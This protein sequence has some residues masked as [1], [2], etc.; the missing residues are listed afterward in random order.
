MQLFPNK[1]RKQFDYVLDW[2]NHWACTREFG[3]GTKLPWDKKW[4]IESLSDSTMQMAYVTIAKYLN[5]Q[6][7]KQIENKEG[8]SNTIDPKLLNDQFFDYIF[9]DEG[10]LADVANQTKISKELI[11]KM[12]NEFNYWYPFDFRNSAKDLIQN[13]LAF[14]LF[15]HTAIFPKKF[16]PKKYVLNGRIM[17]NNEKMSKS[18]GNFFTIRELNQKFGADIIRLTSANAG[19][20]VDD[21]NYDMNFLKTA[22]Q[23]LT[24]LSEFAKTHYNKESNRTNKEDIDLWFE[25][26]INKCIKTATNSL[27]NMLF[28]S[29]VKASLMDL[30]RYLKWYARRT[31]KDFN[32]DTINLFIE[33]QLKLLTPFT[34]HFC[35]EVWQSL[36]KTSFI[37]KEEWPTAS[38]VDESLNQSEELIKNTISSMRNVIKLAKLEKPKKFQLFIARDWLY[39]AFKEI[40]EQLKVTRNIG[41][42]I[43]KLL[44]NP[45]LK[46]N[47]KEVTK[48]LPSL[49]KDPSKIPE[50]ITDSNTEFN[51]LM[52][53]VKF[54][55]SEFDYDIEVIRA[56]SSDHNKSKAA[57]PGRPGILVE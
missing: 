52:S 9:L 46:Q 25:N 40:Q 19:E 55:Q 30:N 39:T 3:L 32:K 29:A 11:T 13:H 6:T 49:I 5:N 54:L 31:N 48:L 47:A 42:I 22:K 38:K 23:K 16:W 14:T 26:A 53:A 56:S 15:N 45:E 43:P 28:K 41:Q 8:N 51:T 4:L 20:G 50:T 24:E 18:K 57:M 17:I 12:R 44:S 7:E 35:E 36:E 33:T 2:L 1:V 37:S 27:E 10:N 34:P 21:A